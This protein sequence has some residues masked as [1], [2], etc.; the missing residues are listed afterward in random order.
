MTGR[1]VRRLRE[2]VLPAGI[3]DIR[4]DG[5]DSNGHPVASGVYLIEAVHAEGR[6]VRKL[7]LI[8]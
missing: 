6:D 5:R 4:W 8:R 1:M 7:T 3:T 2:G